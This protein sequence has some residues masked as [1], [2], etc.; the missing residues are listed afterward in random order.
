MT[1]LL[2][3][4]NGPE[5]A[6]VVLAQGADI[7][8]LKDATRGALGA[9]A[10]E[11]VS[12]TVRAIAGR[13]PVSA[14]VG[15]LPMAPALLTDAVRRMAETG[16]DYVKVGLFPGPGR[17]A[18]IRA[19]GSVAAAAKIIGVMFADGEPD[20]ELV[21]L[22]AEAG[23]AGAMLDTAHKHEGRLL[24]RMDVA[25]LR[26]F[27]GACRAHGLMAGL[28]GSL[29]APDVPRLLLLEPDVLGFRGALCADRDR[30]ARIDPDA[31]RLIRDLIPLDARSGVLAESA[32]ATA[33]YRLLAARGY[34]V[35]PNDVSLTDRIFVRDFVL[36]VRIGVYAHEH[37][38]P[39]RVRFNVDVRVRRAGRASADMRDVFSYDVITDGI[40][41]IVA[42]GHIPL[43]ETL[44]EQVAAIVLSHPR[45]VSVTVQAEKLDLGSGSVGVEVRRE[46]SAEVAEVYHLYPAAAGRTPKAGE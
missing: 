3:S 10:P 19:L 33:D 27:V 44:A 11:M 26:T 45:A 14:V 40:R 7:I 41:L 15:D 29:E 22:M 34:S 37:E 38:K 23:F 24:D 9:V 8:D 16:V 35:D 46:R 42:Q 13:R 39:Q 32:E 4:V 30:T 17:A 36:P 20:N 18:C 2:A 43:V 25:R 5:E 28:A 1:M 31:A 21:S 6:A 12:A